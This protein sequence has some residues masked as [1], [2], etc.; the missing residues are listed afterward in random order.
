MVMLGSPLGVT[1]SGSLMTMVYTLSAER[2]REAVSAPALAFR[3]SP[4]RMGRGDG[5]VCRPYVHM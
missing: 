3:R 4:L 2:Q 1:G 5:I